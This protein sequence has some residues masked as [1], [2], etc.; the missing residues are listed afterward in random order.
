MP[1]KGSAKSYYESQIEKNFANAPSL[2]VV[3]KFVSKFMNKEMFATNWIANLLHQSD[4]A[5]V[6]IKGKCL[7]GYVH[8]LN[9]ASHF[10]MTLE[11]ES[12][13]VALH[14]LPLNRRI[15]HMDATGCLI[16]IPNY[17]KEYNR[18]LTYAFIVQDLDNLSKETSEIGSNYLVLS[19]TSTSKHDTSQLSSMFLN[20]VSNFFSLYPHDHLCYMLVLDLTWASIHAAV[21]QLNNETFTEYNNR[22]FRMACGDMNAFIASK[23]LLASCAN[24]AIHLFY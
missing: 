23:V 24:H 22:V 2:D 14:K 3:K 19:E 17:T 5:N 13:Y 10:S 21:M 9:L 7:N 8:N 15:L 1:S 11:L 4:L 20:L 16:N 18:I 12:Q 6:L